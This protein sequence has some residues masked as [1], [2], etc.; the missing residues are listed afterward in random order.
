MTDVADGP[1]ARRWNVAS[2][3]GDALDHIIDRIFI[4]PGLYILL[5]YL[6]GIPLIVALILEVVTIIIG[7]SVAWKRRKGIR[8]NQFPNRF[9][10][11]SYI[12]LIVTVCMVCLAVKWQPYWHSFSYVANGALCIAIVLRIASLIKYFRKT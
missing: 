9:G 1:L 4:L 7:L 8:T 12:F 2:D 5:R 10:K 6:F 11:N 3:L